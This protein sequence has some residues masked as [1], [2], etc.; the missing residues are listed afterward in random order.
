MKRELR[1]TLFQIE[2][3]KRRRVQ[4]FLVRIGLTPGMGQAR[5]LTYLDSH[6]AVTQR[7]IA[8]ACM[9]DVTT[10]SR[11]LDKLEKA[12]MIL[13]GR[14]PSCRRSYQISLTGQG[15]EKAQE[16]KE[17][18]EELEEVLCF[19]L[20]ENE[21]EELIRMLRRVRENLR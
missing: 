5:I 9:L 17:G 18:F 11:A 16:V 14:D 19:G 6:S 13:R 12:G 7:E 10:M 8:D 1:E 2:L 21:A 15:K 20:T 4:E 3:L